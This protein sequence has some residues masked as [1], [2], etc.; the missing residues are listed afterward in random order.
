[1]LDPMR[2]R[3][4]L[5]RPAAATPVVAVLAV[6]LIVVA[7]V[8]AKPVAAADL[9][10]LQQSIPADRTGRPFLMLDRERISAVMV[11]RS[12][13]FRHRIA[14]TMDPER[15]ARFIITCMDEAST[16]LVLDALRGGGPPAVDLT[17]RCA[18]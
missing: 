18:F 14:I 13:A 8:M 10:V 7:F 15:E 2:P 5:D 12:D 9:V 17:Q 11:E 4:D 16:R 3:G 1:M 6:G